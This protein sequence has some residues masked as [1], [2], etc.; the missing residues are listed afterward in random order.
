[1]EVKTIMA[2][3]TLN[4]HEYAAKLK[5]LADFLLSRPVF[6]TDWT[7]VRMGCPYWSK[8][9]SFLGAVKA[10]SP[11]KKEYTDHEVTFEPVI[12][13]P[14]IKISLSVARNAVCV[15]VRPAEYDCDPLLKPDEEK[16]LEG[17]AEKR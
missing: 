17:S 9:E 3:S 5:Q 16:V 12:G 13:D 2:S 7:Y 1:M 8:K 6:D 10:L 14:R 11:G 4:S 15:L